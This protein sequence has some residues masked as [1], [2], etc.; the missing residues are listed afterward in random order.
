MQRMISASP[1]SL[2]YMDKDN[3]LPI[4]SV[5]RHRDTVHYVPLLAKEGVKHKVRGN[6][7][8]GGLLSLL[9]DNND[10]IDGINTLMMLG[11]YANGSDNLEGDQYDDKPYVDVM[12]ELR[13][14]NLFTK[15][16]IR[17]RHLLY[18][19]CCP[20]GRK[21]RFEYVYDWCPE[22]LKGGKFGNLAFIHAI[23]I[24]KLIKSFARFLKASIKHHEK[25]SGL[26]F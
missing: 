3:C 25:E 7:G 2:S 1:S 14:A 12:K 19:T 6:D 21:Q 13:E 8:R 5:L 10:G 9:A 4:Q 23:I 26:L 22:G 24:N 11:A 15:D 20:E 18:L 16:D 17:T